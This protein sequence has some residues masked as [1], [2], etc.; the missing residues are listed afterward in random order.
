MAT[1]W[2]GDNLIGQSLWQIICQNL[3]RE[4]DGG[5][6]RSWAKTDRYDNAVYRRIEPMQQCLVA[7]IP[8][9]D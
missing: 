3:P 1:S 9:N 8:S 2:L 5:N 7:T 6:C 4:S